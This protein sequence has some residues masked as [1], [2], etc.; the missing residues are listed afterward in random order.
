M[1]NEGALILRENLIVDLPPSPLFLFQHDLTAY[2]ACNRKLYSEI[3][4]KD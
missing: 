1:E 4:K 3:F 2:C